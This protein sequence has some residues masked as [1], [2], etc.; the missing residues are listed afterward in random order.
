M[1]YNE[2]FNPS[3]TSIEAASMNHLK[4]LQIILSILPVDMFS[5]IKRKNFFEE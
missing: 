4:V 2:L 5:E 3:F 1:L